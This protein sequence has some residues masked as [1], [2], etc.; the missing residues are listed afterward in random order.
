MAGS[1]DD[2]FGP[3]SKQYCLYFYVLSVIGL[4][5]LVLF[6]LSSLFIGISKKKDGIFYFQVLAMA[7]VYGM[8][9]LQNR[10]LFVMC[11]HSL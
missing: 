6:V 4:I 10:L 3:L 2:L 11:S 5:S 1:F 8:M 7:I 9:Y